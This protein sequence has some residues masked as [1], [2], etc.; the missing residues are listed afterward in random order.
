[1]KKVE[2]D[3][4]LDF[5]KQEF[6]E[7]NTITFA[8]QEL[9]LCKIK[10]TQT[11]LYIKE[12]LQ[13]HLDT[14]AYTDFNNLC[15]V[16]YSALANDWNEKQEVIPCR[17]EW[18][19][20]KYKSFLEWMD[21]TIRERRESIKK[22]AHNL[23]DICNS[24]KGVS[25]YIIKDENIKINHNISHPDVI[26][27]EASARKRGLLDNHYMSFTQRR[28][29]ITL[30]QMVDLVEKQS[31][32]QPVKK[33]VLYVRNESGEEIVVGLVDV[34]AIKKLKTLMMPLC[35][36]P[37]PKNWTIKVIVDQSYVIEGH[38]SKG[39]LFN[40]SALSMIIKILTDES[41]FEDQNNNCSTNKSNLTQEETAVL[42]MLLNKLCEFTKTHPNPFKDNVI[43]AWDVC[44][45]AYRVTI[46]E[47][48]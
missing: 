25:S 7:R 11:A 30:L 29:F 44:N 47:N 43:T 37:P 35:N 12:I 27:S 2:L 31:T 42:D 13:Q 14:L 17:T 24:D 8:I 46:T 36:P 16:Y 41:V 22:V 26:M 39:P 15:D 40:D 5:L 18:D 32:L 6:S 1:M 45:G 4:I 34:D 10:G 48:Q 21:E 9:M 33:F 3:D 20:E 19:N 38:L 23:S 28:L